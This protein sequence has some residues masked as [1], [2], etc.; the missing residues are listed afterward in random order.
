MDTD[1]YYINTIEKRSLGKIKT[2]LKETEY[3]KLNSYS[4][5]RP[6]TVCGSVPGVSNVRNRYIV[7]ESDYVFI[8]IIIQQ[9]RIYNSTQ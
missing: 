1:R 9:K 7:G 3:T 6:Y 2:F 4:I 8:R 5:G